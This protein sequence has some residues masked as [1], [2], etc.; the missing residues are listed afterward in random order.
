MPVAPMHGSSAPVAG[1]G[2]S[3]LW[4][5][6]AAAS[7]GQRRI[8]VISAGNA[9]ETEKRLAGVM[10]TG[11][12]LIS[13]DNVNGELKG[14]FL[15]QAIEQQYLDLRPL[16]GSRI[17]RIEAGSTTIFT[18]GNNITICGD[19][20]RRTIMSRL[21]AQLENPQLRQ[22]RNNPIQTVLNDRGKYIA[23]C[24]TICRAYIADGRPGVLPRLA[25]FEAWS[26]TVRS[27][28]VWLGMADP[29]DTME[30]TRADD[31]ERSL[32]SEVLQSWAKDHGTGFGSA[33]PLSVI[34]DK[35]AKMQSTGEFNS[36]LEPVLPD[37][38]A[39][40]RAAAGAVGNAK[41]DVVRFG[42]WCRGSKGRIVDGLRLRNKPS[43]RARAAAWWVEQA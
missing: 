31:P 35:A 16:G 9:E 39:A 13:I 22:F 42:N 10:L 7:S 20:C 37:L 34:V 19:L 28:L 38:S 26:D 43:K 27:A 25:S 2:K 12:P 14:D 1:T 18:T 5:L 36:T 41:I 21:D 40:V 17:V 8:P 11:Q 4:D 32:L 29:I 6:S 33:V 24:L 23:A 30:N 15:C 3:F